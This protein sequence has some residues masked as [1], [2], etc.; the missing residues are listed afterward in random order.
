MKHV[1][2]C[3]DS[4]SNVSRVSAVTRGAGG[5]GAPRVSLSGRLRICFACDSVPGVVNCDDATRSR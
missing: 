4:Y 3:V 1:F 5:A 2:S